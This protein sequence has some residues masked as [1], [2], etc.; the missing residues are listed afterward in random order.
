MA[1]LA[2][3]QEHVTISTIAVGED[4]DQDLLERV[5]SA[6]GGRHY[7]TT[8]V[9]EL[10]RVVLEETLV[11]ARGAV[12]EEPF[13]PKATGPHALLRGIDLVSAPR[14]FGLSS[15]RAK[16]L[17][18]VVL[19]GPRGAP[20]LAAWDVGLGRA[21][22]WT[23]D[24]AP[25][26][27]ADWVAWNGFGP[28]FAGI[29]RDVARSD[30]G[31]DARVRLRVEPRDDDEVRIVVDAVRR[32]GRFASDLPLE[33]RLAQHA[34]G[35]A[36]VGS[37][38]AVELRPAGPGRFEGTSRPLTRSTWMAEARLRGALAATAGFA[39]DGPKEYARIG[40]DREALGRIAAAGD[41]TIGPDTRDATAGRS[42][43]ERRPLDEVLLLLAALLL[44]LDVAARR[45]GRRSGDRA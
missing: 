1:R 39:I 22:A 6:G 19:E 42:A 15:T 45:L 13:K 7:A 43:A 3:D 17:A 12:E 41:G 32:D 10:P 44:P 4:A 8:K 37:G 2:H 31:R 26:W 11:A 35:L 20:L 30:G 18:E 24:V 29:A 14:L 23:S 25:R 9:G 16:P 40:V 21:A 38:I 28:F 36:P 27:A 34:S 5:A 33:V